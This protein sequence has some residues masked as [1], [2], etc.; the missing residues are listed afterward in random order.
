MDFVKAALKVLVM[1]DWKV[2]LKAQWRGHWMVS[3]MA[4]TKDETRGSRMDQLKDT[5]MACW[6]E[7]SRVHSMDS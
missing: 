7:L 4:S 3:Q 5:G 2:H 1:A 6:M